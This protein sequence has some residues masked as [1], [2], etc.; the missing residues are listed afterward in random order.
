MIMKEIRYFILLFN[1]LICLP[2]FFSSS[3]FR[4]LLNIFLRS[5]ILISL[6]CI[7]LSVFIICHLFIFLVPFHPIVIFGPQ[8][9]CPDVASWIY[10]QLLTKNPTFRSQINKSSNYVPRRQKIRKATSEKYI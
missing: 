10:T 2:L 8:F 1:F 6:F 3:G 7:F 4:L 9:G 5:Y